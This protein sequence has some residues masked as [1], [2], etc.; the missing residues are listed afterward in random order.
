MVCT[1]QHIECAYFCHCARKTRPVI[2]GRAGASIF[3]EKDF[4]DTRTSSLE[5]GGYDPNA[6]KRTACK[7]RLIKMVEKIKLAP[8]HSRNQFSFIGSGG[9]I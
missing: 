8:D 2:C 4:A 9:R 6:A 3:D 1:Y 7:R 5:S